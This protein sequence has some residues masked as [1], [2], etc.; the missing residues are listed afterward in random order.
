MKI[1]ISW[2]KD[3]SKSYASAFRDWLPNVIQ[4]AEP[5]ISSQDIALGQRGIE[6]IETRLS[7]ISFGVLFVSSENHREPW[8]LYEAGALSRT[9]DQSETRVIPILIDVDRAQL[10]GSPLSHFQ[11]AHSA[12]KETFKKLCEEINSATTEPLTAE[13]L[14]KTFEKWWPDLEADFEKIKPAVSQRK[15]VTLETLSDSI[16]EIGKAIVELRNNERRQSELLMRR[17]DLDSNSRL[18]SASDSLTDA[19][20]KQGYSAGEILSNAARRHA[21]KL[22]L[23]TKSVSERQKLGE[24]IQKIDSSFKHNTDSEDIE[25]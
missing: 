16:S 14:E 20:E 6:E 21:S 2:S 24:L 12:S 13:R 9:I 15:N 3:Y 23:D 17:I 4:S 8:L 10:S 7:T 25:E 18:A 1:F 22:K 5:F 19:L 11:N